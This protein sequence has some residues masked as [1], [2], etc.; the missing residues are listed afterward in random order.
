M[1]SLPVLCAS[2]K[3]LLAYNL[4]KTSLTSCYQLHPEMVPAKCGPDRT[5]WLGGVN[6]NR[7]LRALVVCVSLFTEE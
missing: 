2:R 4:I 7:P 3:H 5:R 6:E 1:T